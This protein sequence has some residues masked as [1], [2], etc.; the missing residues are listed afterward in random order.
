M[1][2]YEVQRFIASGD[3]VA[4]VV[5]IAWRHKAT[6]KMATGVLIDVWTF[7]DGKAI[8]VLEVFDTASMVAAAT[9]G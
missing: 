6:N 8:T 3:D 7:R 9:P 5:N 4:V 1:E 2:L